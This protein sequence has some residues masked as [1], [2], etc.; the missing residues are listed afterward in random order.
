M[1]YFLSL[2]SRCHSKSAIGYLLYPEF[3]KCFKDFIRNSS[4]DS[5]LLRMSTG[6]IFPYLNKPASSMVSLY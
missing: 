6:I 3:Y 5:D 2:L 1:I 4:N